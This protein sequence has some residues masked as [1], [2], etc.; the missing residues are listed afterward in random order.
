MKTNQEVHLRGP[1]R[2]AAT[3]KYGRCGSGAEDSDDREPR[4]QKRDEGS[5]FP[6]RQRHTVAARFFSS[7]LKVSRRHRAEQGC[8]LCARFLPLSPPLLH[9]YRTDTA[10]LPHCHCTSTALMPHHYHTVTAP[11]PHWYRTTTTLSLH[12]VITLL[13]AAES[14]TQYF[15]RESLWLTL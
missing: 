12:R 3:R 9:R 15:F 5:F 2:T 1:Y 4:E 6:V 11:V 7:D 14:E 10:P 13:V 8:F